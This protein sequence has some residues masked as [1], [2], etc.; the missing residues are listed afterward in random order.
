M[1]LPEMVNSDCPEEFLRLAFLCCKVSLKLRSYHTHTKCKHTYPLDPPPLPPLT[2]TQL[3][4]IERP[5]FTDIKT[6]IINILELQFKSTLGCSDSYDS[7]EDIDTLGPQPP[8]RLSHHQLQRRR[9]RSLS[10]VSPLRT[11]V[12]ETSV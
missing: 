2:H 10:P 7:I 5:N 8:N 11:L 4:P 9:S 6:R 12:R 3:L 1:K